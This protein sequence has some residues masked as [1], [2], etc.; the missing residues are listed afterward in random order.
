MLV[1]MRFVCLAAGLILSIGASAQSR[2]RIGQPGQFDQ[3]IL[4]LSWSPAYCAES[5]SRP[6]NDAQCGPGRHFAFV[7]HGL[8][9]QYNNGRWPQFCS[10]AQGLKSPSIM[11][12]IM[13]APSLIRHE[14]ERH[15]T[16]SGL[17]AEAY[18]SLARK[19]FNSIRIP[20]R[21]ESLSAPIVIS[22]AEL[23]REFIQANGKLKEDGVTVQCSARYL[24]EVRICLDKNLRPASC[25]EQRECRAKE[26]RLPPVR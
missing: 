18:F 13:P 7:L 24:S 11:L 14:W 15:G 10:D 26:V 21:F 12:D 16:C 9:P 23:K 22:P 20:A 8:W 25:H 19:A 3:Y 1:I 17:S 5:G 6:G 2:E 4:A